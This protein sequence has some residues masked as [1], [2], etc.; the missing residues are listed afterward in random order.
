[1]RHAVLADGLDAWLVTRYD[2]GLTALSAGAGSAEL[3]A[4]LDTSPDLVE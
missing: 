2:D 3:F 4:S 1:M